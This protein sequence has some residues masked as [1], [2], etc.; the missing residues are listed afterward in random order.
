ML[1]IVTALVLL[2]VL[3]CSCSSMGK[4]PDGSPQFS[5]AGAA[6]DARAFAIVCEEMALS[7]E[8]TDAEM[9]GK[10][11]RYGAT[12]EDLAR[13]WDQVAAGGTSEGVSAAVDLALS[14]GALL[15]EEFD[16]DAAE[17]WAPY[18]A[19]LRISLRFAQLYSEPVTAV[20]PRRFELLLLTA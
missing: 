6:R 8:P 18:I 3:F 13:T 16:P 20:R 14:T 11:R 19:A 4:N 17:R 1:R 7:F 2:V 9:A 10:L 5:P 15:L 12:L